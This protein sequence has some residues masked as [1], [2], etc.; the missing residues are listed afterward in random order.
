MATEPRFPIGTMYQTSGKAPRLCSVVDIHR[1]YDNAGN[2]VRL[3]YV[4]THIFAGQFIREI[5][6]GETTIARGLCA[7]YGVHSV[8]EALRLDMV[9]RA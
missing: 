7:L 6:V 4:T 5:G 1:T 3:D 8:D 9:R 2:L